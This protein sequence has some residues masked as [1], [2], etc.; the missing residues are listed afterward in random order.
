MKSLNRI[1]PVT[2]CLVSA[3]LLSGCG[4]STTSSASASHVQTA[5]QQKTQD[6]PKAATPPAKAEPARPNQ[7][8][9][10]VTAAPKT[11]PAAA[12]PSLSAV[13]PVNDQAGPPAP[14]NPPT[15]PAVRPGQPVR[16]AP[17][18]GPQP[19]DSAAYIV[20][21]VPAE[22][23]MGDI[24][25][26]DTKKATLKLSN[27]G[28]TPRTVVTIKPSCGCTTLK[29]T[30]NTVIQPHETLELDVQMSAGARPGPVHGKT[31]TVDV[32]GQPQMVVPL[33]GQAVSFVV[34]IPD[35]VNP[36]TMPEGKIT[37]KAVDGQPFRIMSSQPSVLEDFDKEPSVEHQLS[38]SFDKY[39]EA[40]ITRALNIYLDHPKCQFVTVQVAWSA[41]EI[42]KE[43]MKNQKQAGIDDRAVNPEGTPPIKGAPRDPNMVQPK[44]A[45]TDP[46]LILAE[47]IKDGK[48]EEVIQKIASGL[49]V[50][51]RD[52][53]NTSLLSMA[54]KVG[55]VDLMQQLLNT[56]KVDLN[57]A[58]SMGRTALMHAATSKNVRAVQLL[59]QSGS[60]AA[61]KDA[62]GGTALSWA[63]G[64][65][66]AATVRELLDKG[67]NV[68][69]VGAITGWTPLI[70]AAG[71]GDPAS[72]DMLVDA[73]ANIEAGDFLQ[74]ATPLIFASATGKVDAIKIL[75][76]RGAKIEATD[77]NGNTALLAV[78]GKSG[79]TVDKLQALLDAG[80]NIHARDNRGFNALDLAFK[81]T[82]M[83][84]AEVIKVLQP[85]LGNEKPASAD[86][87]KPAVQ[88]TGGN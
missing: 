16:P 56:K 33:K 15:P 67:A 14:T 78:A 68:E 8:K 24:P 39:R 22:I 25:T 82:D 18:V 46:D 5:S 85:L 72:I 32:E 17:P 59:L 6:T 40:G 19:A 77:R 84:A 64:M 13:A 3:L 80:A 75:I 20:K 70:W 52:A 36:E 44:A 62:M 81:R 7:A 30:P 69:V 45:P 63:A 10:T 88:P 37:L 54:A 28:D 34:I 65:G 66:D 2:L 31:L 21:A 50:N 23:D 35:S 1:V 9:P 57:S 58:D 27:T 12:G 86:S 73:H 47:L 38:I 42:T 51:H 43:R 79:G 60:D 55:N 11:T 49:D 53:S 29:F 71:F 61:A 87:H 26:N 74:G 83:R 76:K 4:D 41:E 48:N